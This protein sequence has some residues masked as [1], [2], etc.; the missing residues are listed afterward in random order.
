MKKILWGTLFLISSLL[1]ANQVQSIIKDIDKTNQKSI[2]SQKKINKLSSQEE[3]IYDSY[4]KIQKELKQQKLY[5]E[6]LLSYLATQEKELPKLEQQLSEIVITHKRII[7]LMFEMV[8]TLEK[9]ID[10]DK[11]FLSQ[12]RTR[13]VQSLKAHLANPNIT[14]SEQ[15]RT[16]LE[17]YKIEYSYA[18]T[19]EA[20][21]GSFE[22]ENSKTVDFLRIGR[23][24]L[25]Y[26][27]LDLQ[28]SGI[29][30]LTHHKWI[31]LEDKYNQDIKKAIKMAR[32][33]I[34]PDFLTLP[35]L[36]T[37]AN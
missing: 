9:F 11:P 2:L 31:I 34:A 14:I 36:T 4:M 27:S 21:R 12:E 17:A 7:P 29:Y 13:R 3:K 25:Y 15:F 18:R 30:D 33:K 23:V 32:K 24:G 19:L 6:Q 28:E 5:N 1:E 20:Y 8:V 22:N 16:I 37:K 10:V 26:Q 35:V